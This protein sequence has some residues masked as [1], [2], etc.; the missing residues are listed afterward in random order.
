MLRPGGELE[1][2]V[3]GRH[4]LR[5]AAGRVRVRLAVQLLVAAVRRRRADR[6]LRA[7]VAGL[8]PGVRGG[9]HLR[10]EPRADRAALGVELRREEELQVRLVPD[11]VA[12]DERVLGVAAGV[13]RREGAREILQV[14]D[15]PGHDVRRLAAVRPLG[16][17][18]DRDHHLETA[19]LRV[20][21]ELI[22]VGEPVRR[23][24]WVGRV[25]RARS[26]PSSTSRPGCARSLRSRSRAWSSTCGSVRVPTEGDVVVEAD[27]HP[28]RRACDRR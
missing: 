6:D 7:R 3:G 18:P 12:P 15:V 10:V 17:A 1:A 16:R 11:R 28:R 19:Q 27:I 22:D 14:V 8:D 21:D 26:A 9:V 2:R 5:E 13:A 23:V 24:E 25:R 20:A 4:E